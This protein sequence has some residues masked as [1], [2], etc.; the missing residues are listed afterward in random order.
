MP[1]AIAAPSPVFVDIEADGFNIDPDLIEARDHAARRKAI[2][3]VHQIG[4]PCDLARVVRDRPARM[5]M[6]VI[7]DAACAIGSEILW[8]GSWEKIGK[9]HGDIACFS[10][11][12]RKVVTTG[13]GG[14][15]TTADPEYDRKFRLWRQ[16]GMSV[17]DTVRHGV[18]AGHLSRAIRKSATTT[19]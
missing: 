13:D 2:L 4:M 17:T 16:H 6:P 19:A 11:H 18:E 3:C 5:A 12:P 1:S 8:D 15:L 9:P 14:M 10:F 7:E